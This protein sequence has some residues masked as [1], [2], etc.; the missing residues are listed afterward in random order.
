M[1]MMTGSDYL[2][3]LLLENRMA[4]LILSNTVNVTKSKGIS[5]S[6]FLYCVTLLLSS[7]AGHH[8]LTTGYDRE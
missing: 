7:T 2:Q 3:G 4:W 6:T 5:Q 1:A 8:W